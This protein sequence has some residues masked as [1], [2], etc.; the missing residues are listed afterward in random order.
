[1]A[2][3]ADTAPLPRGRHRL[4][5]E[6]VVSSQR[7]RL[8]RGMA[9]AVAEKGY[10]HTSVA[11]VLRRARVSRES[12][13][14]HFRDKEDCFLAA[15]DAGV[16]SIQRAMRE[17]EEGDELEGESLERVIAAYLGVLADDPAFARTC[18]IEIY[19]VGPKALERRSVLRGG[20]VDL[21]AEMVDAGEEDRFACEAFVAAVSSLVT[22][23]VGAGRT[24]ELPAL[25]G[26]IIELAH[27]MA[28]VG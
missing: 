2:T 21:V 6:T 26:P 1:M 14:E 24:H 9:E 13:Y 11:E 10:V 22:D 27:R 5:R 19:A 7:R 15:Y 18:L 23:R 8:V 3:S 16:G 20:F 4:S 12:F 28:L 25:R 17:R